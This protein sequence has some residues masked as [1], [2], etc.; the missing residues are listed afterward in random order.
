MWPTP[1]ARSSAIDQAATTPFAFLASDKSTSTIFACACGERSRTSHAWLGNSRSSLKRPLPASSR[2]SSRRF[3]E[4]AAPNRADAGSNCTC[5]G[6]EVIQGG[7]ME[8]LRKT[9]VYCEAGLLAYRSRHTDPAAPSNCASAPVKAPRSRWLLKIER[10]FLQHRRDND[11]RR[12]AARFA[13]IAGSPKNAEAGLDANL[14]QRGGASKSNL[15]TGEGRAEN[16]LQACIQRWHADDRASTC[17]S[18]YLPMALVEQHDIAN[19]LIAKLG[20][21]E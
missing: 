2:S 1:S 13:K 18:A 4:R 20:M 12:F 11:E 5:S 16:A 10:G 14:G 8:D 19:E 21:G 15:P 17:A 6:T 3:C 9:Q 7:W